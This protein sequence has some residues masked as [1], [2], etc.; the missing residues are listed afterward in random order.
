MSEDIWYMLIR[1]EPYNHPN[2]AL[3]QRKMARAGRLTNLDV[4][5][6]ALERFGS[7]AFRH[8]ANAVVGYNDAFRKEHA[9]RVSYTNHQNMSGKPT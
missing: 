1:N 2:E 5:Q 3:T 4:V 6:G 9:Q 7:G 8:D